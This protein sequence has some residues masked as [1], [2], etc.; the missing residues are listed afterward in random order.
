MSKDKVALTLEEKIFGNTKE[1]TRR[2][3]SN[4]AG[5]LGLIL[6]NSILTSVYGTLIPDWFKPYLGLVSAYGGLC[7]RSMI[8]DRL[9]SIAKS[10]EIKQKLL[11]KGE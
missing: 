1:G 4:G 10:T 9:D 2:M 5:I 7:C 3:M 11:A 8:K 6:S